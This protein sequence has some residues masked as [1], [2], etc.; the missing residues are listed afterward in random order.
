VLGGI[1]GAK[2]LVASAL[3]TLNADAD[4]KREG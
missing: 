4:R 2:E 1:G 3:N